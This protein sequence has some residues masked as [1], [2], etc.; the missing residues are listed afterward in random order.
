M[1]KL[2]KAVRRPAA[3]AWLVVAAW[4]IVMVA[5]WPAADRMADVE[6]ETATVEMVAG[7]DSTRVRQLLDAAGSRDEQTAIVLVARDGGLTEADRA[8]LDEV[9]AGL[10]AEGRDGQGPAGAVV[11]SQDGQAAAFAVAAFDEERVVSGL[12][13]AIAAPP[14]GL[15]AQVTGPAALDADADDLERGTDERLLLATVAVVVILLII[16][17]RSPVLW[18]IPL[19]AVAVALQVSRATVTGFGE[20]GGEY[21]GLTDKILT[22][23]VFGIG[24]D[25]ALLL[26]A[27]YRE[28]LGHT[29]DRYTAMAR[30]VGRTARAVLA[31]AGTVVGGVLCLLLTSVP[32]TRGL[33]PTLGLAVVATAAVMLTL[34]PAILVLIGRWVF[35]PRIPRLGATVR[36][37]APWVRIAAAVTHRPVRAAVVSAA[38]LLSLAQGVGALQFGLDPVDQFRTRPESVAGLETLAAH[39]PTGPIDPPIVLVEPAA[40]DRA[41]AVL[42]AHPGVTGIEPAGDVPGWTAYHVHLDAAPFTGA[43]RDAVVSLRHALADAVG[44]AAVVG[45]TAA[46]A[47]DS[48]DAAVRDLIVVVPAILVIVGLVLLRTARSWRL[49]G[50]LLAAVALTAV[51]AAGV[52]TAISRYVLDFDGIEPRIPLYAFVFVVA[53]G[54][55]YSIFVLQR[56][57][58]ERVIH[59]PAV[60]L[61]RAMTSTGAVVTSAGVVLAATFLVLAVLPLVPLAQMG[62]AVAAGILL[63]TFVVRTVLMPAL[64]ILIDRPRAAPARNE[65][66]DQRELAATPD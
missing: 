48:R 1:D 15:T 41:R 43:A 40:A 64:L 35:W 56:Y 7:A 25:Y 5:L 49:A 3:R 63:D 57:R 62:I 4:L 38:L 21:S 2:K 59:G 66:S 24:T 29:A 23:L 11:G 30:A 34:L 18:M 54:V 13:R 20:L 58:E 8:W 37:D 19:F 61:R 6:T 39:F 42:T 33:G 46:E 60:S 47:V 52:A 50:C 51:S 32:E 55:D 9:R 53:V 26:V 14:S 17:Y 44:T 65:R 16:T 28:E 12:R 22:V 36:G 31:S 27:R 45:G 10:L